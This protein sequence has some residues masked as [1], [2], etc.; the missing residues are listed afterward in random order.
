MR[1]AHQGHVPAIAPAVHTNAGGIGETFVYQPADAVH[2]VAHFDIAH[3]VLDAALE[4]QSPTRAA[5][6]VEREDQV[7]LRAQILHAHR[8]GHR[9]LVSYDLRVGTA[10]HVHDG[11]IGAWTEV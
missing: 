9:P 7:A 1:E 6:V 5:S 3:V 8:A 10:V 4:S 11:R 2:L